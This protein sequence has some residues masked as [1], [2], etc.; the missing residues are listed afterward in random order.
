MTVREYIGARYVPILMGEWDN[1]VTY[2]PLSIVLYQGNSYTSRQFVPVGTPITDSSFWAAT[3]N[4]NAQV[5]AY[6]QEVQSFDSRITANATAITSEET[7]RIAADNGLASDITAEE[8]ARIAADGE[9]AS[10]ITAEETARIAADGELASDITAEETARIAAD[11]AMGE[12][13]ETTAEELSKKIKL[14]SLMTG[15]LMPKYI[16]S[17][18]NYSGSH[19][20]VNSDDGRPIYAQSM[21]MSSDDDFKFFV[22][23]KSDSIAHVVSASISGNTVSENPYNYQDWGHVNNAAYN[24][25]DNKYYINRATSG[26]HHDTPYLITNI[27][28]TEIETLAVPD[29]HYFGHLMYDNATTLMWFVGGRDVYTFDYATKTFTKCDYL[30][31]EAVETSQDGSSYSLQGGAVYDGIYVAPIAS[32]NGSG[33]KIYDIT[34]GEFICYF[35]FPN[36]SAY[37][38]IGEVEGCCFDSKGNLYFNSIMCYDTSDRYY[39]TTVLY[40]VN[41]FEGQLPNNSV[42]YSSQPDTIYVECANYDGFRSDGSPEYPCKTLEEASF[43]IA[44]MPKIR[45]VN[46]G[47]DSQHSTNTNQT[48]FGFLQVTGANLTIHWAGIGLITLRGAIISRDNSVIKMRNRATFTPY[49]NMNNADFVRVDDGIL[50]SSTINTVADASMQANVRTVVALNG[51]GFAWM[52]EVNDTTNATNRVTNFNGGFGY[53]IGTPKNGTL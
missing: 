49:A 20:I 37:Y 6:R 3:G 52:T 41:F 11:E 16:G 47:L 10:D 36:A 17:F 38:P 30:L 25:T 22:T 40:K 44:V 12:Q 19:Y 46:F 5:E 42:T 43:M 27:S 39:S 28:F 15:F 29:G 24:R 31:S 53:V 9:L 4:Y 23:N 26:D 7:A 48:W 34:T 21:A 18:T 8:T 2:E 45:K 51:V 50:L 35:E 13:I 1:T 33:L 32:S 14:A